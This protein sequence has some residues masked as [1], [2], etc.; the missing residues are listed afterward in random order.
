MWVMR[1]AYPSPVSY[2]LAKLYCDDTTD[3]DVEVSLT[4]GHTLRDEAGH[5][6]AVAMV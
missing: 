3:S 6:L 4:Y 5:E 2:P 1:L